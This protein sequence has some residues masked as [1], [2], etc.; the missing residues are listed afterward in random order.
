[1]AM[2]Q[3]LIRWSGSKRLLVKYLVPLFPGD[4]ETFYDPFVGGGSILP[5]VIANKVIASD[6]IPDGINL[7]NLFKTDPDRVIRHYRKLY[8]CGGAELFYKVRDK[9][10]ITR[11]P[12]YF[13][14]LTRNTVNGIVCYNQQGNFNVPYHWTR[15]GIQPNNL[16]KILD[17]WKPTLERVEFKAADY[18]EAL[19]DCSEKDFV[20]LD[21]PYS[22]GSGRVYM[23]NT[24]N[25]DDFIIYLRELNTRKIR[26]LLTFRAI[27]SND[28]IPQE[29]YRRRIELEGIVSPTRQVNHRDKMPK[30]VREVA[31]LNYE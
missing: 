14:Y 13:N 18:R 28:K 12:L 17:A 19:K 25:F 8:P 11:N 30:L 31:Y 15:K 10:N 4:I 9:F 6:I 3:A 2:S 20:F 23:P 21:P 24:F 5:H 27:D 29:L 7:F 22:G 26:W 1:M 16:S